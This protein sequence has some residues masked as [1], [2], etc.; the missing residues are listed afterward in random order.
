MKKILTKNIMFGGVISLL[1][2][3]GCSDRAQE[4]L[5][6]EVEAMNKQCPIEV[7]HM[8]RVDSCEVLPNHTLRYH[9]TMSYMDA[10]KT[11]T[12]VFKESI[13]SGLLYNIQTNAALKLMREYKVSFMYTI[14]DDKGGALGQLLFIFSD[15]DKPAVAP[16]SVEASTS[17][18]EL[19]KNLEV[20][21]A[22]VKQQL[23][24]EIKEMNMILKD[25]NVTSDNNLE[26][27]Y[28]LTDKDAKTFDSVAYKNETLPG[29]LLN[30][31]NAPALKVL[32]KQGVSIGYVYRDKA[33]NYLCR[34]DIAADDFK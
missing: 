33:E 27:V 12:T 23:P 2:L 19:H 24:I 25:C 30:V 28:T 14:K 13:T 5:E 11:D 31:K 1:F 6:T 16:E 10:S 17:P 34:I 8:T 3:A 18:E 7:D 32:G 4:Y 21:V 29:L 15:Y 22:D 20:M 9:Y 26:Y